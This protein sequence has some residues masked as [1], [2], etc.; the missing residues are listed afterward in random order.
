MGSN[1]L[2]GTLF[3]GYGFVLNSVYMAPEIYFNVGRRPTGAFTARATNVYP[4]ELLSTYT[5]SKLN[6]WEEGLDGR[7]GWIA[8]P[9][10]LLFARVGVAV[11]NIK[12]ISDTTAYTNGTVTPA[13]KLLN[14]GASKSCA[15]LRVGGGIEQDLAP[16][17]RGLYFTY[18]GFSA[19]DSRPNPFSTRVRAI[20][21]MRW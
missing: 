18:Y 6:A 17:M 7:L 20:A 11:N 13:T 9:N 1:N 5:A 10:T 12:L 21:C 15:G 19:N 14:Y 4:D 2:L 16:M 3:L 8:T